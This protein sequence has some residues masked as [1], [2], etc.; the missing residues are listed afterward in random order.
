MINTDVLVIGAGPVGLFQAFQLGL[1]GLSVEVVDALPQ[2]GGQ[3]VALYPDKPIYDIPGIPRISGLALTEQLLAQCQPFLPID[4]STGQRHHLHLGQVIDTLEVHTES[5]HSCRVSSQQGQT[6][7]AKAVV[8]AGG[9]GAFM[10][11]AWPIP[12]ISAETLLSNV[13]HHLPAATEKP[14]WAGQHVVIVGGGD[15]A[16]ETAIQLAQLDKAYAPARI[17]LLHRRAQ[18]QAAPS[19]DEQVQ[20]LIAAGKLALCVGMPSSGEVIDDKLNAVT[21]TTP[22]GQEATLVFDHL[23]IRLGLS[24]KLGPISDWG[25][26][27]S[28]KQVSVESA[29]CATS[30]PGIYAVGDMAAYPGKQRLIVCGFHEATLAA[31]ACLARIHPDQ[32]G[33]LQYTTTSALL[34]QRLKVDKLSDQASLNTPTDSTN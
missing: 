5:D 27:M 32:S 33:P 22:E 24:P 21:L 3:C 19:L 8:I 11:R 14:A 1:L 15:E 30:I 17:T 26:A 10:P 20:A 6:W 29:T 7:Q 4:T 31:H 28:R 18:F 34:Q 23:L 9:V 12:G 16:L 2:A 25:L 13:L